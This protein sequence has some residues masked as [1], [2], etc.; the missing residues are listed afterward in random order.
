MKAVLIIV[1]LLFPAYA[2]ADDAGT[3]RL[4]DQTFNTDQTWSGTVIIDGVVQFSS[5]ASLTILP[6]TTVKFTRTDTDGDG[7]GENEIYIQGGL[8]AVG[9]KDRPIV[10]TSAEAHPRPGDW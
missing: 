8:N 10:F 1:A 7:I 3:T 5:E 4:H 9:T 2:I 6:G